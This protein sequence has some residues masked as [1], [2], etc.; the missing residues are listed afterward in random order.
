MF[1]IG[2]RFRFEAS[3]VLEGMPEGHKCARLHGHSWVIEVE[4]QS[5]VLDE[6]GMVRDYG[7]LSAFG[8]WIQDNLDHRHLNDV[9]PDDR[10]QPTSEN[11]AVWLYEVARETLPE[12]VAVRVSETRNTWAEYR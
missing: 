11:V 2:K 6:R 7:D 4:L 12:V 5:I 3:H 8:D 1:T 9:M 10:K